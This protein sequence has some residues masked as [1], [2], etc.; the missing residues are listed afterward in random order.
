[1]AQLAA[2]LHRP[3]DAVLVL[4]D[5]AGTRLSRPVVVPWSDGQQLAPSLLRGT[6]TAALRAQAGV[7]AGTP[8]LAD[9]LAHLAFPIALTEQGPLNARDI[10]AIALSASGEVSPAP[11]E[12]VSER[13]IER[14]GRTTLDLIDALDSNARVPAPSAYLT[15]AG[16]EVPAW[17][18]RLLVLALILPVA[19]TALDGLA[20]ARRRGYAVGRPL[21]WVGPFWR[22]WSSCSSA[23]RR[24]SPTWPHRVQWHRVPCRCAPPMRCCW[25]R[26]RLSW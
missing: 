5:M 18:V 23:G 21:A 19:A 1:V 2:D 16:K 20:R 14:F 11:D 9:Q 26:S 15:L 12:A 3:V 6:A 7:S 17:A 13:H 8:G 22:R 10:P 4:G 25:S 24:G